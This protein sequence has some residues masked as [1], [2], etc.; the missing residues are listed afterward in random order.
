[1]IAN[2]LKLNVG[3][4]VHAS[5]KRHT[6]THFASPPPINSLLSIQKICGLRGFP[7]VQLTQQISLND[8]EQLS[9]PP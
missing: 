4:K 3:I 7:Q 6:H 5:F 1:M 2:D 8:T 9:E